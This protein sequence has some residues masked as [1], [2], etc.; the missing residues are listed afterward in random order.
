MR[1]RGAEPAAQRAPVRRD[2]TGRRPQGSR[3]PDGDRARRVWAGSG[4]AVEIAT[5]AWHSCARLAD[6]TVRCWGGQVI[7]PAA[8][9]SNWLIA[10]LRHLRRPSDSRVT[11]PLPRAA[12]PPGR[13]PI[14][15]TRASIPWSAW[16]ATDA[17]SGVA[18]AIGECS[19]GRCASSTLRARVRALEGAAASAGLPRMTGAEGRAGGRFDDD[20]SEPLDVGDPR[21]PA[22][23]VDEAQPQRFRPAPTPSRR[24]AQAIRASSCGRAASAGEVRPRKRQMWRV[25][26]WRSWRVVRRAQ[27]SSPISSSTIR[28]NLPIAPRD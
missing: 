24:P 22:G 17:R 4:A 19:K 12:P 14:P 13:R 1:R 28:L 7:Q 21:R 27:L 6:G 25:C 15:A 20:H 16:P 5:G 3:Q 26:G 10:P 9:C 23:R 11:H 18:A 8:R 2:S